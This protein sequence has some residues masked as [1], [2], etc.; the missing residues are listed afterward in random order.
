VWWQVKFAKNAAFGLLPFSE[1]LRAL[2]RRVSPYPTDVPGWTL[3]E[4]LLQ[5]EMLRAAGLDLRGKTLLEVGTGWR[6]IIPLLFSLAGCGRVIT[7][8]VQRLMDLP[9]FAGTARNLAAHA[10]LIAARLGLAEGEVREAL[11]AG[12]AGDLE[13]ALRR[14]R[15]EYRAPFD[16]TAGGLPDGSVDVATSRAVLEHVPPATLRS[17]LAAVYR[18]LR[19]GG[20]TCHAIDNSDHW[21]HSD[22]RL[23]RVN[24]LRYGERTFALLCR[25][26]PLDY[27]NRLRHFEYLALFRELGFEIVAERAEPDR[28]AL[29]ALMT[30]PLAE[31]F[32]AVPHDELAKTDSYIVARKPAAG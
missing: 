19:P 9:T 32:R 7:V 30:L 31:R 11:S 13:G 12:G 18:A 29:E 28:A 2:K 20:L 16:L 25:F 5:V 23:S 26:N 17:V 10:P 21:S 14:F 24:F 4:G 8:D 27:Q 3:E 15:L 1:R 22:R 6:P